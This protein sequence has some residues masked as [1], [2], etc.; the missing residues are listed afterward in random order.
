MRY[1]TWQIAVSARPTIAHRPLAL[2]RLA[3]P[4]ERR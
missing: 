3:A 4:Q 2:K 1:W